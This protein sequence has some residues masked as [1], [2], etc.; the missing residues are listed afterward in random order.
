MIVGDGPRRKSL[1]ALCNKVR[2][3]DYIH[4]VGNQTDIRPYLKLFD[5]GVNCSANEGLSNAIMEYMLH[6]VPCI[7]SEAG[8]ILIFANGDQNLNSGATTSGPGE[9]RVA[10]GRLIANDTVINGL[11]HLRGGQVGSTGENGE[12]RLKDASSWET[13]NLFGS[14]RIPAGNIFLVNG[15]SGARVMNVFAVLTNEGT[16]RWDGP[17]PIQFASR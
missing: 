15:D 2:V 12:F 17:G 16:L 11:A 14:V 13:G 3:S 7:V 6:G 1:E 8:G 9:V 4:F 10:G 5:V